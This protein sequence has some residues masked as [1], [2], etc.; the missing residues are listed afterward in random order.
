MVSFAVQLSVWSSATCLFFLSL[1]VPWCHIQYT[2]KIKRSIK[3]LTRKAVLNISTEFSSL[4][5]LFFTLTGILWP[6]VVPQSQHLAFVCL[7]WRSSPHCESGSSCKEGTK[8]NLYQGHIHLFILYSCCMP[9]VVAPLGVKMNA[10]LFFPSR[11]SSL[12]ASS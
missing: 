10:L 5:F 11:S 7:Q 12:L 3:F 2:L 9:G 8:T 1:S 6:S 4:R